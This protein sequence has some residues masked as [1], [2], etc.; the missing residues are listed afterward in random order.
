M[1]W[2][3]NLDVQVQSAV[4]LLKMVKAKTYALT[5]G[6]GY[7]VG[8]NMCLDEVVATRLEPFAKSHFSAD[9]A[10]NDE[11][12]GVRIH[13]AHYIGVSTSSWQYPSTPLAKELVMALLNE[14]EYGVFDVLVRSHAH[15]YCMVELG[16]HFAVITPAWQL[17]TPYEVKIGLSML[18]QIGY[19]F[20][21]VQHGKIWKEKKIWSPKSPIREVRL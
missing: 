6:S 11:E 7:H 5:M 4:E 17:R 16:S 9:L 12:E 2:T 13:C 21:E 19:V 18:P 8:E 3:T 1:L 14:K 15:Y 10:L 20:M